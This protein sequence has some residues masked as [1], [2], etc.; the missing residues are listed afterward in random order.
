MADLPESPTWEG[1]V[2]Q[3]ES[4]DSV[5]G[6]VNGTSNTQAKQLANRTRYLYEQ[7][8]P[9]AQKGA[10]SGV[11][12][13][14]ADKKVPTD[15]L[16]AA[17]LGAVAYQGTW[18]ANANTPAL[19]SSTGTKGHYYRVSVAGSTSLNGI[20]D[21]KIGDWAIFNGTA[22]EK[23]DNTDQVTSVNGRQGAVTTQFADIT[24]RSAGLV[25]AQGIASLAGQGG[26]DV[27]VSGD[28]SG[29]ELSFRPAEAL[30]V[31]FSVTKVAP[32]DTWT[33]MNFD[34]VLFSHPVISYDAAT[35]IATVNRA[36][37]YRVRLRGN[38]NH[39]TSVGFEFRFFINGVRQATVGTEEWRGG[40]YHND[41]PDMEAM[42]EVLNLAQGT[43]LHYD[44]KHFGVD[45][46][47]GW[48]GGELLTY[49]YVEF[50]GV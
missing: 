8:I 17:V 32:Y 49:M 30:K 22:W 11:A 33:R 10:A 48:R 25:A 36:G 23:V 24:D 21:W 26:R 44:A 29:F 19:A 3:I 12:P 20:T 13:L 42:S 37:K 5:E 35:G 43:T 2:Y 16:P 41:L 6:G 1:G 4:T 46:G 15:Y 28:G 39:G 31:T 27:R 34:Q 47:N 18:D 40:G 38:V 45:P 50:I 7:T 9:L 14:G